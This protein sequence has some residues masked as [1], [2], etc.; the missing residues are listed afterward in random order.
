MLK[1]F[2]LVLGVVASF[3]LFGG[4]ANA[5]SEVVRAGTFEGRN[6]HVVTGGVS[7]MKTASGYVVVLEQNFSLDGAPNPTL[8]FGK[9][10]EFDEATEFTKLENIN[11]LQ[12]YAV[13]AGIDP[14]KFDEFYVWCAQ[15]GVSLGVA[16]LHK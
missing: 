9:D 16:K 13:P 4:A 14:K 1:N 12:I 5:E 15:V 8:G 6:D 11:G 10:G 2:L 3:G 7:V